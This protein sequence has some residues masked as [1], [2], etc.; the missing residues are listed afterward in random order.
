MG[1]F[2]VT[3]S[4]TDIGKT[5]VAAGLARALRASGRAADILK[6]IVSGFDEAHPDGSDPALLLAALGRPPTRDNLAEI[7]P[8]RFKAPLSP[9]MAAAAEGRSL[10]VAKVRAF[11]DAAIVRAKDILLIEGAG[12]VMAPLN[13]GQTQLDLIAALRLPLIFIGGSYL[14]A[15]SHALS[16]LDAAQ[17]RG[18]E[19]RAIVV[20]ESEGSTV[21]LEATAATLRNF[22]KAPVVALR[23][24]GPGASEAALARLAALI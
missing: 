11:C 3:G 13:G 18:L 12:G 2:F 7:S 22:A 4:G 10:D 21:D 19:V 6:P 24:A 14:G 5:F 9:D 8:W 1:A 16:A 23:R 15:I 20:N 17:S